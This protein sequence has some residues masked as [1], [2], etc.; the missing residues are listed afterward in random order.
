M[1]RWLMGVGIGAFAGLC[2][3][4]FVIS[5]L[6]EMFERSVGLGWL[7]GTRGPIDPPPAVA[8]VGI[9]GAT[10]SDLGLPSVPVQWPRTVHGELIAELV[11]RE[12]GLIVFDIH[13]AE[14]KNQQEDDA[15]AAAIK[16]AGRVVLLEKLI[17]RNQPLLDA[18]GQPRG[19]LWVESVVPPLEILSAGSAGLGPFPLPKLGASVYE[20]WTFKSSTG[21]TPTLPAVALQLYVTQ[22]NPDWRHSLA[23]KGILDPEATVDAEE[24]DEAVSALR[25]L[26]Q[27]LRAGALSAAEE[28][29]SA[30]ALPMARADTASGS[31]VSLRALAALY[32]KP[33]LRYLNLYGPPGTIT[34]IPYQAVVRA[35]RDKTANDDLPDLRGKIVF[36]GYSDLHDPGQPDRFYTVFTGDDG[37]DL[38]GVEIAATSFANLLTDSAIDYLS[39]VANFSLVALFGLAAGMV[40]F[41]LPAAWGVPILFASATGYGFLAQRQFDAQ[42]LWLPL[43]TP[44]LAQLPLA[45]LVGLFAQYLVERRRGDRVSAAISYYLP[46]NVARDLA[47]HALDPGSANKVVFGTCLATDMAG[48]SSI[49]EKLPPGELAAFLND[50]FDGLSRPLRE[51]RVDVTE[52]RADGIMCAWTAAA[53]AADV[54]RRA[55]LAALGAAAAITEFKNRNPL[56]TSQLRIGLEAG[57]VYVGHAGGGGHFV[58]SIVGDSAN[59]ASRLESLNKH[60]GSQVLASRSVVEDLDDILLRPLGRFL[61]MGKSEPIEVVEIVAVKAQATDTELERCASF[62]AALGRF[63]DGDWAAAEQRFD[64]LLDHHPTDGPAA[65][66][67]TRCQR[68]R[69]D[70]ALVPEDPGLIRMAEK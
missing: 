12:V 55:V 15:F 9:N 56:L 11:R 30:T 46:D 22:Q 8:V 24:G 26:M 63:T 14:A 16:S 32:E 20:F 37:V 42:D 38:A 51:H 59:T 25:Y 64:A 19:S 33:D 2:G 45:L 31:D 67:R 7:F 13:F 58:Y 3:A 28:T 39:P 18:Q 62:A 23:A 70:P 65:F 17:A 36:V 66:Y 21:G 6:G 69:Q 29:P 41:L 53:P 54:R 27:Q 57:W 40:A 35:G 34:T 50:Y 47:K 61:L 4:L 5:P 60:L 52:F 48:F 10:G 1:R 49:A 44:L 68:Y 43:A